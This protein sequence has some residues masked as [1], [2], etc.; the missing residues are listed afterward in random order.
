M[1]RT[2]T[3][4]FLV[5]VLVGLIVTMLL[6]F[7]GCD[8]PHEALYGYPKPEPAPEPAK[9]EPIVLAFTASWCAPCQRAKPAISELIL[10]G[11]EV[12]VVDID[13]SP[14]LAVEHGIRSV[15]TF[16][17]FEKTDTRK[18]FSIDEVARTHDV[19]E[20]RRLLGGL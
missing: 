16:V 19:L 5:G 10:A 8:T 12:R 15:P 14:G 13:E 2:S 1:R 6:V 3:L 20:L 4:D 11:F 7:S 18:R 17:V 9:A